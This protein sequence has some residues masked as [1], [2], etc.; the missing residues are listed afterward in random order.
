MWNLLAHIQTAIN[1]ILFT[2]IQPPVDFLL[3]RVI[4]P[5]LIGI[6]AII[7]VFSWTF[8]LGVIIVGFLALAWRTKAL[9]PGYVKKKWSEIQEGKGATDEKFKRA[10]GTTTQKDEAMRSI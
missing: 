1:F 3:G 8:F 10:T 2:I 5:L 9:F 7:F 6:F 4:N